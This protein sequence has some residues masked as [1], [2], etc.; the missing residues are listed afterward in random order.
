MSGGK[1]S[2]DE[3]TRLEPVAEKP[4]SSRACARFGRNEF[5]WIYSIDRSKKGFDISSKTPFNRLYRK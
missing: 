3:L 4:S 2:G 5:T 1:L